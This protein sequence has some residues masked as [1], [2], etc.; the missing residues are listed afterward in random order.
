VLVA[1]PHVVD[2]TVEPSV[3]ASDTSEDGGTELERDVS[4]IPR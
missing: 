2:E 3:L 1:A 4:R